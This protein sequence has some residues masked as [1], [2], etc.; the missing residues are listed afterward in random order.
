MNYKIEMSAT[1]LE[2]LIKIDKNNNGFLI[3][4][5]D[6]NKVVGTLTD[7]DIRRAYIAGYDSKTNISNICIKKFKFLMY[8][9]SVSDVIEIFKIRA[10]K[11]LPIVDG[12]NRLINIIT[13]TQIHALLLQDI[14]A[15]IMYDFFSLDDGIMDQ[16]ILHRP[17]GFYKSTLIN[18]YFQSKIICV[19][20]KEQLSLQ[21]HRYREEHWTIVNGIGTVQLDDS[22][23]E[24]KR[25]NTVFI[26]K[27]CRHRL[28]NTDDK[29][30]LIIAE[31]QIGEYFGEDDIIRYEDSYGRK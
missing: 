28:V 5:D 6:S 23:I 11:F 27:G 14:R 19:N 22:V 7:G 25:G 26:P 9:D 17:W 18:D 31:V 21:S 16:E 24:V 20:P 10:I 8:T 13:K 29:E 15:D 1:I 2:A 30:T 4:T 3:V 12:E